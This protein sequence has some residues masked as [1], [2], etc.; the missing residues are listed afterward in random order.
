VIEAEYDP[1]EEFPGPVIKPMTLNT[2]P[3]VVP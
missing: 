3:V 1:F 2:F